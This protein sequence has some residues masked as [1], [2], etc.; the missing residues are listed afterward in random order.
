MDNISFKEAEIADIMGLREELEKYE[1][2]NGK[3][4]GENTLNFSFNKESSL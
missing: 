4:V 3:G 1:R 2:E